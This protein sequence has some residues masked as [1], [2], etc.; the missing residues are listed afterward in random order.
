MAATLAALGMEGCVNAQELATLDG[1]APVVL[2]VSL[3][4]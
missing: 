1:K 3:I 2:P 4:M